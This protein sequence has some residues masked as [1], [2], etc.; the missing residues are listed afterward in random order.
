MRIIRDLTPDVQFNQPI[1]TLGTY[2][3]VHLGH[4]T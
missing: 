1:V 3:G 4:Q 2:D